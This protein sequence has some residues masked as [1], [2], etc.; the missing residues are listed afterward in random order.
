MGGS[1][2]RQR[3]KWLLVT[4]LLALAGIAQAHGGS[5]PLEIRQLHQT[6]HLQWRD[7]LEL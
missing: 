3:S 2:W 7:M 6:R 4:L 1:A 5:K